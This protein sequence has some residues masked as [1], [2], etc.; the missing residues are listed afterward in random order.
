MK[1]VVTG[2]IATYGLGGVVWDYGQYALALEKLGF[3]V[4]YL[5]YTGLPPY[6]PAHG[7]YGE[8]WD[9]AA[10]FLEK[11][12]A[13][14]SPTLV[15]RWHFRTMED[16]TYG[17]SE[18]EIAAIVADADLFLNVSGSC[19]LRPEFLASRR[20]VLIDTDPGRNH[21]FTYRKWDEQWGTG[22]GYLGSVGY[23]AHDHFFTYAERI[24]KTDCPLPDMGLEW[25]PT[26][27]PVVLD[28]W[29]PKPPG[30]TWTT[31]M[32]WNNFGRPFEH[33]GASYG[34]KEL[35]FPMIEALPRMLDVPFEIAAGGNEVPRD[36][37]REL[38]WSVV[39]SHS[40]S[41]SA[42]DYRSYIECS[43]GEFSVAKN[44]YVRTRCGW[45]SCRSAC[46]LASGRP[47]VI[48][49]TGFSS[50]FPTGSG[51]V[52]FS[53]AEEARRGI[54]RVEANYQEHCEAAFSM[55]RAY[56]DSDS[57]LGDLLMRVGI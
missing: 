4:Y 42:D 6:G 47:V 46:Y 10:T 17:L 18:N 21:F 23:R 51:L 30:D 37:L 26:R 12:L 33:D 41:G 34:T 32:S 11:A 13:D 28:R 5:E 43:R 22:S 20:K 3:D 1:A 8:G 31:V 15:D 38:G 44:V 36:H 7:L 52:A 57:V 27:P 2:M 54:E 53:D 40:I 29:A 14:L 55:A 24:G 56:L 50:I 19:L 16:L 35:E 45:F 49:D 9:E 39:D 48:Q 25:K